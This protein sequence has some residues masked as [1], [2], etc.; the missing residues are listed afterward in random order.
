M[1]IYV[2]RQS[3]LLLD[4]IYLIFVLNIHQFAGTE[5]ESTSKILKWKGWESCE[6]KLRER[7]NDLIQIY[8]SDTKIQLCSRSNLLIV[9][10]GDV[11][12]F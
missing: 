10:S 6:A 1:V 9:S 12:S 5:M 7:T 2:V 3:W 8:I 4:Y 11:L